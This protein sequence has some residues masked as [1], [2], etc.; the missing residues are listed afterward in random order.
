MQRIAK[1]SVSQDD[2]TEVT[3][4]RGYR[5]KEGGGDRVALQAETSTLR[6]QLQGLWEPGTTLPSW[7]ARACCNDVTKLEPARWTFVTVEGVEPTHNA[8]E[9][10]L[11]PAALWRTGCFGADSDAGT[12]CVAKLLTASA[13]CRQQQRH[14]LT[15]L[16]TAA[17]AHRE[18][19]PAPSFLPV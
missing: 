3:V 11:R 16:T 10:A 18:G 6:T 14:L 1:H 5:F 19:N 8:A 7:M 9:R 2:T 4:Q 15:Y 12:T 17:S 13:T